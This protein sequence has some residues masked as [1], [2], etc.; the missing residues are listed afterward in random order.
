MAK[1]TMS[2][3]LWYG[4]ATI[5]NRPGWFTTIKVKVRLAITWM[6]CACHTSGLRLDAVLTN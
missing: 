2:D 4:K 3:M 1:G 5:G 6:R